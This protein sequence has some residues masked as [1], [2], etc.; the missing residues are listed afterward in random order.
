MPRNI[1]LKKHTEQ[2]QL[3][4]ASLKDDLD[5][6]D[7]EEF[8]ELASK[9]LQAK[10]KDCYGDDC[11]MFCTKEEIVTILKAILPPLETSALNVEVQRVL[12]KLEVEDDMIGMDEFIAAAIENTYWQDAGPLVVKELMYLDCLSLFYAENRNILEDEDY[13]QLK[14]QLAWEGSIAVSLSK[15]EA[16]FISAVVAYRRG[17]PKMSDE[18]YM[19]LKGEL[20]TTDSWVV[21]RG[22]D[23]LETM[24]VDTFMGYLHQSMSGK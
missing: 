5:K 15:N 9:Y 11:R 23:P 22:K 3:R 17:E 16:K 21:K 12:S 13:M 7:I 14:D 24:G 20:E 2:A 1:L 18:E 4:K 8:N 10:F 19:A 6:E